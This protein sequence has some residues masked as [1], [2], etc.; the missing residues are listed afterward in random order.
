MKTL[1][2]FTAEAIGM[3]AA[4]FLIARGKRRS[5]QRQRDFETHGHE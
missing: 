2:F 4:I 1:L 5:A 3:T